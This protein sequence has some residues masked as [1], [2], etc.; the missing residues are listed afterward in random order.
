MAAGFFFAAL[1]HF[2][3]IDLGFKNS[4]LRKQVDELQSEKRRLL[5]AKEISLSP[6]EITKAARKY[7]FTEAGV[8][9]TVVSMTGASE[10]VR[11]TIEVAGIKKS[12][13]T[14]SGLELTDSSANK[15][16]KTS[17]IR[18]Q[19]GPKAEF[20]PESNAKKEPQSVDGRPRQVTESR[21][22]VDSAVI[23]SVAK[24]R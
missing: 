16:V 7:G 21:P 2:A 1:Q 13:S 4:K 14:R 9:P 15:V 5:L 20:S 23:L 11:S 10:P 8:L 17:S 6:A 22:K 12:E 18:P 19:V 24:L 3:T